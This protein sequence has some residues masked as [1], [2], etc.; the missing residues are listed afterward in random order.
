MPKWLNKSAIHITTTPFHISIVHEIVMYYLL[1]LCYMHKRLKYSNRAVTFSQITQNTPIKQSA[2]G[3]HMHKYVKLR[4]LHLE[5]VCSKN[6][7]DI[8]ISQH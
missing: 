4:S 7:D 5:I 3:H 2:H 8:Y 6:V 1:N